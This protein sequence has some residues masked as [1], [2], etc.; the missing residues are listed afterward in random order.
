MYAGQ[1]EEPL[2]LLPAPLPRQLEVPR[3]PYAVLA[4]IDDPEK[5]T[6]YLGTTFREAEHPVVRRWAWNLLDQVKTT[7]PLEHWLTIGGEQDGPAGYLHLRNRW[8]AKSI[9]DEYSTSAADTD[10]L[11]PVLEH[12]KG[13]A[14]TERSLR[15]VTHLFTTVLQR[16]EASLPEDVRA[17]E[18]V[19]DDLRLA[20]ACEEVLGA[21]FERGEAR[22]D[23]PP[24]R[25]RD[26][27][28]RGRLP[29]RGTTVHLGHVLEPPEGGPLWD[30]D[31]PLT[32]D[33]LEAFMA[34]LQASQSDESAR[35]AGLLE[36]CASS[37]LLRPHRATLLDAGERAAALGTMDDDRDNRASLTRHYQQVLRLFPE[38]ATPELFRERIVPLL[39]TDTMEPSYSAQ[40]LIINTW[41]ERPDLVGPVMDA[42]VEGYQQD[43]FRAPVEQVVKVAALKHGWLP[44]GRN[45]EWVLSWLLQP[46]HPHAGGLLARPDDFGLALKIL[47]KAESRR[48]GL[49]DT[50]VLPTSSGEVRPVREAVLERLLEARE[51]GEIMD[52]DFPGEDSRVRGWLDL[53]LEKPEARDRL[54]DEV[55]G[56]L[57]R[58]GLA[59]LDTRGLAALTILHTAALDD[60][61]SR[62]LEQAMQPELG[63][64]PNSFIARRMLDRHRLR[65]LERGEGDLD[66]LLKVYVLAHEKVPEAGRAYQVAAHLNHHRDPSGAVQPAL[67]RAL[68]A[69]SNPEKR[70]LGD[71]TQAWLGAGTVD[72]VKPTVEQASALVLLSALG[73]HAAVAERLDLTTPEW[74]TSLVLIP[75]LRRAQD[76]K[77]E[78]LSRELASE[79]SPRARLELLA[80][81]KTIAEARRSSRYEER[82]DESFLKGCKADPH[83][84][85]LGLERHRDLVTVHETLDVERWDEECARLKQLMGLAEGLSDALE[86]REALA[87]SRDW[88]RDLGRMRHLLEVSGGDVAE[89]ASIYQTAAASGL[90]W[91]QAL[92]LAYRSALTGGLDPG[93]L[94]LELG[95][96]A[97]VIGNASVAINEF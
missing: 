15:A 70:E 44:E 93:R 24:E 63:R 41:E 14:A 26:V 35:T 87:G 57:A 58:E 69:L 23:G 72:A 29:V 78:A 79:A 31:G 65:F 55:V 71:R 43:Y 17:K 97:V 38:E 90:E 76:E 51:E 74:K 40:A 62:R 19:E 3:T 45:L 77:V 8:L 91:E 5:A 94:R 37:E 64:Q 36:R 96:E 81:G 10:R 53:A 25:L 75:L 52:L 86:L 30:G 4:R 68:G 46:P 54:L 50:L 6:A 92:P 32:P 88:E 73:R 84:R 7:S 66:E 89:A 1:V 22:L 56:A 61:Q 59:G 95:P 20:G 60:G 67:D 21:W 13:Q 28:A 9:D 27:A 34:R 80:E 42:V 85:E 33:N 39:L 47:Q 11:L 18:P 83:L 48:P 82:L 16:A 49:L 12:L 2:K